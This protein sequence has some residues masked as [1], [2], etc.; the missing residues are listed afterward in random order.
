MADAATMTLKA[1]LLPDEIQKTL[2]DLT[3]TYAPA[4]ATEGWYYGVVDVLHGSSNNLITPSSLYLQF[5]GSAAGVDAGSAMH[6]IAAGDKVKFLFIKNLATTDDGSTA[7]T[8]SVYLTFDGGAAAHNTTDAFDVED[9]ESWYCKP[10]CTVDEIKAKG[11]TA[12]KAGAAST[13]TQCMVAA[14]IDNV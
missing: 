13:A 7:S 4:N 9:G 6:G 2:I 8:N 5:G 10:G 14:I 12:N 1:V 3:A 11:G